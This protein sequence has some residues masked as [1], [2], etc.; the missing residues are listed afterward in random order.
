MPDTEKV[1]SIAALFCPIEMTDF[2]MQQ[3]VDFFGRPIKRKQPEA[4]KDIIVPT[5]ALKK[6]KVT[7]KFNEGAS[8]AVRKPI[9]M[10]ALL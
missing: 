2:K 10:S 3:P 6:V 7:Y 5:P 8:S 1:T 4:V 9:K